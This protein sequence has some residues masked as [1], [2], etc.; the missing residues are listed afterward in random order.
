MSPAFGISF[1]SLISAAF[2]AYIMFLFQ[3][4]RLQD[5]LARHCR[6]QEVERWHKRESSVSGELRA[7]H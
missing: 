7:G 3:Q 1:I 5:K 6:Q 4:R 2:I